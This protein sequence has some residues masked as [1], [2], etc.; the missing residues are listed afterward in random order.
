M[1]VKLLGAPRQI[2]ES[3]ALYQLQSREVGI[4]APRPLRTQI[5]R[6][7]YSCQLRR[8]CSRPPRVGKQRARH[9][10]DGDVCTNNPLVT[11]NGPRSYA[12]VLITFISFAEN[13]PRGLRVEARA[14]AAYVHVF[15]C[16]NSSRPYL[17]GPDRLPADKLLV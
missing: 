1:V 13:A 11:V 16:F 3:S 8:L 12:S 2:D 7:V 4:G 5:T 6:G 15:I 14:P 10:E 17:F 9:T